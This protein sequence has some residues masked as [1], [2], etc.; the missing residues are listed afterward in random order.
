VEAVLRRDPGL[1][2]FDPTHNMLSLQKRRLLLSK[3]D[4][5]FDQVAL[6]LLDMWNQRL[7]THPAFQ[8]HDQTWEDQPHS[9]IPFNQRETCR[10]EQCHELLAYLAIR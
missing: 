4:R 5:P 3:S 2:L 9:T 10:L 8:R 6:R 7:T 1:T